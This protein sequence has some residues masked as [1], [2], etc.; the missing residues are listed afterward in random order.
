MMTISLSGSLVRVITRRPVVIR[1]VESLSMTTFS[2]SAWNYNSTNDKLAVAKSESQ[3]SS[4]MK[5]YYYV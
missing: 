4:A 2:T 1:S 5:I 3:M